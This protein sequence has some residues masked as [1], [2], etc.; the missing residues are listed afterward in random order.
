MLPVVL[1]AAAVG[2]VLLGANR[3]AGAASP[4]GTPSKPTG[5]ITPDQGKPASSKKR[6]EPADSWFENVA[7]PQLSKASAVE[8]APANESPKDRAKREARN[9]AKA[10]ANAKTRREWDKLS[11]SEKRQVMLLGPVA[12]NT[13]LIGRGVAEMRKGLSAAQKAANK[14]SSGVNK[15]IGGAAKAAGKKMG[16]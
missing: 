1:A 8:A 10:E 5:P 12:I 3:G 9:R 15:T 11:C 16:F 14:A 6:C 7:E 13:I 2:A 4:A